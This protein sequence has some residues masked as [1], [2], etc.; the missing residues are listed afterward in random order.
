VTTVLGVDEWGLA[1][2]WIKRYG[3]PP[4]SGFVRV[5]GDEA[6]TIYLAAE[7]IL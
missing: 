3:G 5:P 4:G 1:A 2:A 7:A 6:M